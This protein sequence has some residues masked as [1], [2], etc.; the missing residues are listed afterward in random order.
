MKKI[1]IVLTS[2]L[3]ISSCKTEDEI[4]KD[5]KIMKSRYDDAIEDN[6]GYKY[7][8]VIIEGCEFYI[9]EGRSNWFGMSKV[10]CD[11]I[12]DKSKRK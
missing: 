11:C 1:L 10:D 7:R 6:F 3:L 4:N 5:K 8:I 12:P 9:Y 2:I